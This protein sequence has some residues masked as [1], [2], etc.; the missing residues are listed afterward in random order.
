MTFVFIF[1]LVVCFFK[2]DTVF[3][4]FEFE[5]APYRVTG[6]KQATIGIAIPCRVWVCPG[7]TIEATLCGNSFG[8]NFLRLYEGGVETASNDDYW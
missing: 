4:I 7:Q 3:S 5:C 8:D 1:F 2:T 6:D